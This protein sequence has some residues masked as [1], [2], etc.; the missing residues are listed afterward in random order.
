MTKAVLLHKNISLFDLIPKQHCTIGICILWMG[1]IH[2]Y[3]HTTPGG[4]LSEDAQYILIPSVLWVG[5]VTNGDVCMEIY[6]PPTLTFLPP[7]SEK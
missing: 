4:L 3:I 5:A 7:Q 6:L 2:E 1:N